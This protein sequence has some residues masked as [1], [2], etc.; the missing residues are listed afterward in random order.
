MYGA[1]EITHIAANR[2]AY[3]LVPMKH[4]GAISIS[5]VALTAAV[6]LLST[7]KASAYAMEVRHE[8]IITARVLPN[9][10]VTVDHSGEIIKIVSNTT[11]D[12]TPNV[13]LH[14]VKQGHER[15]LTPELYAAYRELVQP[16][17]SRVGTLYERPEPVGAPPQYAS[18]LSAFVNMPLATLLTWT[19]SGRL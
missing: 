14:E 3:M 17:S 19:T 10:Y 13:Y 18:R 5:F 15:E 9:H 1:C 11:E 4:L 12:V 16:G 2:L 7:P 8:I 6:V